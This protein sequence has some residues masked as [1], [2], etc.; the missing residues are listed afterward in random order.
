MATRQTTWKELPKEGYGAGWTSL[1]V[2]VPIMATPRSR[3]H[4]QHAAWSAGL[5]ACR[6]CT[7]PSAS[8]RP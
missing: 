2:S 5:P 3:S 4:G 1:W 6:G 7:G 8:R